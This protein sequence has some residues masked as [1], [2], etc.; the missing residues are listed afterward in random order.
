MSAPAEDA[1]L[2]RPTAKA[3]QQ[4]PLRE[5]ALKCR[6]LVCSQRNPPHLR[7]CDVE[8]GRDPVGVGVGQLCWQLRGDQVDV[9]PLRHHGVP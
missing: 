6:D 7:G 8:S 5:H 2:L 1:P 3:R 9:L 4:P